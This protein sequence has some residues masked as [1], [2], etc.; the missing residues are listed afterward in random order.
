M[1]NVFLYYSWEG[2]K[3]CRTELGYKT[4]EENLRQNK[5]MAESRFEQTSK[6]K[7]IRGRCGKRGRF[8]GKRWRTSQLLYLGQTL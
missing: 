3:D 8:Q 1:L 4:K 5:R 2:I 6:V 7:T